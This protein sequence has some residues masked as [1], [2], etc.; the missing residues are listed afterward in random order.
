MIADDR[1]SAI[2]A[3]IVLVGTLAAIAIP[4]LFGG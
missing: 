4:S 1:L 3:G 2:L